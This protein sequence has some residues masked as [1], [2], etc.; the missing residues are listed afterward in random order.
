MARALK[1]PGG[2]RAAAK[3][4]DAERWAAVE[5]FHYALVEAAKRPA[6]S[7]SLASVWTAIL[8]LRAE[9]IDV[10]V[11]AVARLCLE[12]TAKGPRAQS[13]SNDREGLRKLVSLAADC[14]TAGA[15]RTGAGGA[16]RD[17]A[18]RVGDPQAAA[19]V[20][21]LLAE[22]AGLHRRCE[23]LMSSHRRVGALGPI[24]AAMAIEKVT[25]LEELRQRIEHHPT[26]GGVTF[27]EADGVA[28]AELVRVLH[29]ANFEFEP[30][31]GE[32]Y[33][34]SG[35]SSLREVKGDLRSVL[36]K[37][38]AAGLPAGI[39]DDMP[40]AFRAAAIPKAA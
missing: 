8:R 29:A 15:R 27:S 6:R 37:V 33:R 16:R 13:I 7:K 1:L 9:G 11:T 19:E 30:G 35:P 20:R 32:L 14:A 26:S 31:S 2:H 28:A 25:D 38:M 22:N 36:R 24:T 23:A 10:T 12:G 40:D 3:A 21:V 18:D 5:E 34:V 17:L 4:T 39:P